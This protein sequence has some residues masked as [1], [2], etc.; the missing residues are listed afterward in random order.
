LQPTAY[1][2]N[3]QKEIG[4]EGNDLLEIFVHIHAE[5][6]MDKRG[7]KMLPLVIR[8]D[9]SSCCVNKSAA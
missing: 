4:P 6:W 5:E 1:F 3:I 9:S 8:S 2:V 7:M